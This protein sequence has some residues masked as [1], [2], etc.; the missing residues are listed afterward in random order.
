[1][2]TEAI[3]K[4]NEISK[5]HQNAPSTTL[6]SDRSYCRA[7]GKIQCVATQIWINVEWASALTAVSGSVSPKGNRSTYSPDGDSAFSQTTPRLKRRKLGAV[8]PLFHGGSSRNLP[9]SLSL[10]VS[11]WTYLS[12]SAFWK[13]SN[14]LLH[15]ERSYPFGFWTWNN[16]VLM[17]SATEVLLQLHHGLEVSPADI[18]AL[19]NALGLLDPCFLIVRHLND[20]VLRGLVDSP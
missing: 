9:I 3:C 20:G 7:T 4:I 13:E 19:R 1:M 18:S 17:W 15:T 16:F 5:F 12:A 2:Y 14:V 10:G 11:G 6:P 8:R